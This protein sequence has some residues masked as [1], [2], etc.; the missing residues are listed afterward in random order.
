M[1][2]FTVQAIYQTVHQL[3]LNAVAKS[4]LQ[5][6]SLLPV[7]LGDH[8]CFVQWVSMNL[9]SLI[10]ALPCLS[11]PFLCCVHHTTLEICCRETERFMVFQF[12]SGNSLQTCNS[13]LEEFKVDFKPFKLFC[14]SCWTGKKQMKPV[15]Y[16]INW[17]VPQTDLSLLWV[18]VK[19]LTELR[20]R[21]KSQGTNLS[22]FLF[23]DQ[24]WACKG[25]RF[26]SVSFQTGRCLCQWRFWHCPPSSQVGPHSPSSGRAA[27]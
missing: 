10:S 5:E 7:S 13:S 6:L 16:G 18:W 11:T 17:W 24:G 20:F 9:F 12:R 19:L 4:V 27:E 2:C 25:G 23:S 8:A 22:L 3:I 14:C 1:A 15:T 26:Q 21:I